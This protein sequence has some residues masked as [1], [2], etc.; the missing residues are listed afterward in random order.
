MLFGSILL[1]HGR[2]FHYWNQPLNMR[3]RV[4]YLDSH[5]AGLCCYLTIQI[6]N[7]L[8]P[9]QLFYFHL[10]PIYWLSLLSSP[11]SV[12]RP[13]L[14]SDEYQATPCHIPEYNRLHHKFSFITCFIILGF[15]VLTTM[16]MKSSISCDITPYSPLKVNGR[17]AGTC[18]LHLQGRRISQTINR[19]DEGSK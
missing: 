1:K 2:R 18:R 5:E 19:R 3:M 9:L 13:S 11:T 17:Y 12:S 15:E 6:G 14:I 4:C 10:W 8:R 7:L 16:F